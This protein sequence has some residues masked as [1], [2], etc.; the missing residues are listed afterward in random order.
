MLRSF[1]GEL[2]SDGGRADLI[3]LGQRIASRE[4]W[5]TY[6]NVAHEGSAY[7]GAS[8]GH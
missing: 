1:G 3:R 7:Y 8:G 4:G 2:Y 5:L 6:R